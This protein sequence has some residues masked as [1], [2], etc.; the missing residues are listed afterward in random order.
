MSFGKPEWSRSAVMLALLIGVGIRLYY[1]LSPVTRISMD[2]SVYGVQAWHIL[3]GERSV[4]YYNQPYTGTVSAYLAALLFAVLGVSDIWL[5]FVPF[6]FSVGFLISLYF[7]AQEV[8]GN[9]LISLLALIFAS[10]TSP[11]WAN[12]TV[13]A[14][15][16][17]P[18]M[19]FLGNLVLILSLRLIFQKLSVKREALY[20]LLWGMLL[21]LG[22]WIQPAIIYYFLPSMILLI[23]SNPRFFLKWSFYLGVVGFILGALPVIV[24]N[25]ENQNLTNRSLFHKPFGV[26][27]SIREFFTLGLPVI[28]GVRKPF[29]REDFNTALAILV[30]IIYGLSL[31]WIIYERVKEFVQEKVSSI[32]GRLVRLQGIGEHLRKSDILVLNLFSILVVFSLSSPFNQFV[33]EPRYIS[34]LYTPLPIIL[35]Y[36][37]G[38]VFSRSRK[39]GLITASVIIGSNLLGLYLVP[40]KDF[41]GQFSLTPVIEYLES[42]GVKYVYG[43]FEYSYR[44]VLE[45]K[46]EIVATPVDNEFGAQRYPL[47]RKMV[48][49]APDDQKGCVFRRENDYGC[50]VSFG[51]AKSLKEAKDIG[52]FRIYT[53]KKV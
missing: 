29:S 23:L 27:K 7:L 38:K 21:G 52:V 18:E 34:A 46:E 13:R 12:W 5:K 6:L 17:Y 35:A 47:F 26:I 10:I 2:E 30:E 9:R 24:W 28:F 4:F 50:R 36:F 8:F 43:E 31:L 37:T 32:L 41:Y 20:F 25:L 45:T 14:G 33:I 44:L 11:F 15:S 49:A 19:M 53:R 39:I 1:L 40:P 51:P 48:E 3:N 22:Y 16:G 42:K